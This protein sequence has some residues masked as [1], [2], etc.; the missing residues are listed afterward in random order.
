MVFDDGSRQKLLP[1]PLLIDDYNAHM[2]AVDIAD[3]YRS[4]YKTHRKTLRT[5][6][7]LFYWILDHA[8]INA[9]RVGVQIGNWEGNHREFRQ[10]LYRHLFDFP[11][12]K[13][14]QREVTRL[15]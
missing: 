2:G 10:E 7:P 13:R 3:Q 6:F 15:G 5:W 8:C 4:S 14:E 11:D 9:F 1:I 12:S